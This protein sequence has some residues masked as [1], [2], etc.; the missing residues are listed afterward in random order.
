M[1]QMAF[2]VLKEPDDTD[3][4]SRFEIAL[5]DLAVL[6]AGPED[7]RAGRVR[8]LLAANGERPVDLYSVIREAILRSTMG[9]GGGDLMALG[10]SLLGNTYSTVALDLTGEDLDIRSRRAP[11]EN[12][13]TAGGMTAR[14]DLRDVAPRDWGGAEIRV[15][16]QDVEQ[17]DLAPEDSVLSLGEAVF[18]VRGAELPVADM[19]TMAMMLG[20]PPRGQPVPAR[21]LV[22]G[23][24]NFGAL[25]IRTEGSGVKLEA[26][27]FVFT[28][29]ERE[30]QP[31]FTGG[32]DSWSARVGIVG[33]NQDAGRIEFA[34]ESSGGSFTPQQA[35]G[36]GVEPHVE[37]WFPTELQL[38]TAVSNLNEAFLKQLL[39]DVQIADLSEP[40]E[41]VLPMVLYGSATVLDVASDRNVYETGLFR[42]TQSSDLQFYPTEIVSMTPYTGQVEVG[43]RGLDA[44][45]AYVDEQARATGAMR[46]DE[47]SAVQS[48][49]TVMSNLAEEADDGVLTWSISRDDI[50]EREIV[51]NGVTLRYPNIAQLMPMLMFGQF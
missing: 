25:E 49:F 7:I 19:L 26:F 22:D 51:V 36:P 24:L 12:F 46:P 40:V 15:A 39:D 6:G 10:Q 28:D 5:S 9:D 43:L 32:Y 35:M 45:A 21:V 14:I 4:E 16:L 29:G 48:V 3:T 20:D 18:S 11:D 2:D 33:L 23:L 30:L 17:R 1:G 13:L 8:V 34:V 41:L 50:Y 31:L 37:A 27:D 44:L 38:H 47:A 42:L